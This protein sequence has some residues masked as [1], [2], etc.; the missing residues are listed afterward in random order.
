MF[1]IIIIIFL[2][3]LLFL[4]NHPIEKEKYQPQYNQKWNLVSEKN[5]NRWKDS[6]VDSTTWN[7]PAVLSMD[8]RMEFLFGCSI[9]IKKILS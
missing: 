4:C 6:K 8:G 2:W 3:S 7:I 5:L 9:I 1:K